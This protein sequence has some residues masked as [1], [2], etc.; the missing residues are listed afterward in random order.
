VDRGQ[1]SA[2]HVPLL[3]YGVLAPQ[4]VPQAP[5]LLTSVSLSTSHPSETVPLQS[6]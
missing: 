5:Q 2:M 4:T 1:R 6:M 3:Q